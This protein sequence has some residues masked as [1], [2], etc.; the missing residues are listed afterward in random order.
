VTVDQLLGIAE[1]VV[2]IA[3]VVDGARRIAHR[4]APSD[5]VA[6]AAATVVLSTAVVVLVAWLLAIIGWLQPLR[7]GASAAVFWVS[8]V[9]LS[10]P[11]V[12]ETPHRPQLGLWAILALL[13]ASALAAAVVA[14]RPLLGPT[15]AGAPAAAATIAAWSSVTT[16]QAGRGLAA[17]PGTA[18]LLVTPVL[19]LG[20]RPRRLAAAVAIAGAALLFLA[21]V[22]TAPRFSATDLLAIGAV[23]VM[24]AWVLRDL[25]RPSLGTVLVA[26][27]AGGLAAGA[28]IPGAVAAIVI[29]LVLVVALSRRGGTRTLAKGVLVLVAAIAAVAGPYY[30]PGWTPATRTASATAPAALAG[31]IFAA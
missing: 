31:D 17:A 5:S 14:P 8:A 6:V 2:M 10:R 18:M 7:V 25:S 20:P 4:L 29:A 28:R 30:I 11:N 3:L 16:R 23:A 27:A 22:V 19:L 21:V 1:A 15:E 13:L 26:G 9:Y 24:L 12:W